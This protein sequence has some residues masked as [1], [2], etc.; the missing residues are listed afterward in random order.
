MSDTEPLIVQ[1]EFHDALQTL[2]AL[3]HDH[4]KTY[5]LGVGQ[6]ILQRFFGGSAALY[7]SHDTTKDS[8]FRDFTEN[9]AADLAELE[10]SEQTLRRCV[11]VKVCYDGLP[12]AIRDQVSWSA[13]LQIS[14]LPDPNQRARLATAA[15]TQRWPVAKVKEAVALAGQHRLWDAAPDEAGLQLPEPKDPP[16]PQPGRLAAQSE[17]WTAEIGGWLEAFGRVDASKLSA[18][19][20]ARMKQAVAAAR[21]QLDELERRLGR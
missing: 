14:S 18:A 10:L 15:A 3:T 8:K 7:G 19:H 20:V 2:R 5:R 16:P 13:L 9:H 12:P 1:S 11:R 21:G 17:K 6:Y 4:E